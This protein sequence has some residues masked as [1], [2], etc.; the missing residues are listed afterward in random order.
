MN[1]YPPLTEQM[2]NL[3]QEAYNAAVSRNKRLVTK[4]EAH[5]RWEICQSCEHLKGSRCRECGCHMNVKVW[6]AT[7]RCKLDPPKWDRVEVK[8]GMVSV[9]IPTL[10]EG[11]YLEKTVKS[12]QETAEGPIELLIVEDNE[13][14]GMRVCV[15]RGARASKGEFL[16]SLD[17]HCSV[18][19]GWDRYLKESCGDGVVVVQAQLDAIDKE[20]W[21]SLG[22]N[23]SNVYLTEH[24]VEKWGEP[25]TDSGVHE[26]MGMTG[27]GYLCRRTT[28]DFIGG[29]D[30]GLGRFGANGPELA[31]KVW[32]S[33]GRV[34][35]DC[36]VIVGHL[37]K[38]ESEATHD[39][40]VE[41]MI[42]AYEGLRRKVKLGE[43]PHQIHT[44]LW[45]QK[46]F[47]PP[48]GIKTGF[49]P[50][51][52]AIPNPQALAPLS[53]TLI[54]KEVLFHGGTGVLNVGELPTESVR[55]LVDSNPDSRMVEVSE[56]EEAT[57]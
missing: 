53:K 57:K 9:I 47:N 22:H 25:Y 52:S 10:N 45:L 2:K 14:E 15:N 50:P 17:G 48:V 5:R 6:L 24:L 46:R 44:L 38:K 35:V 27:C 7:T 55:A 34:L 51:A 43:L 33:G 49:D 36:R 32:L 19:P 13:R 42:R 30:E 21:G 29:Y 39:V 23:Y 41:E 54:R 31:S 16:F 12:L 37:F 26:L 8:K 3:L 20:T 40:K 18:S 11:V 1:D 28:W 56:R 4:E